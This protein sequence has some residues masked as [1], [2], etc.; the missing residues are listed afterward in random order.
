M[1][2]KGT[3]SEKS[4]WNRPQVQKHVNHVHDYYYY[5]KDAL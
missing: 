4:L 2:L 3:S 5:Y 1:P